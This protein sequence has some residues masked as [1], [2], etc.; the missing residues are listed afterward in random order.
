MTVVPV[1]D[2]KDGLDELLTASAKGEEV[3]IARE[4]GSAFKLVPTESP[5]K[6]KRGGLGIA[7]EEIW[8]ADDFD[9]PLENFKEYMA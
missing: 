5:P 3:A 6:K 2:A 7:K 4:D 9:E 1:K 8:L